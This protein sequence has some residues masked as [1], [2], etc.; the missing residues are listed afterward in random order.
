M[1][2]LLLLP[3]AALGLTLAACSNNTPAATTT[4]TAAPTTT[5]TSSSTSS[6]TSGATGTLPTVENATDLTKAPTVGP[7]T[8]PPPTTLQTKDLVV[9]TGATAKAGDTV[10]VQYV[11]AHYA[12]GTP[13][14]S[15]WSRGQPATF[16]LTGVIPGFAQGIEGMQVG[17]RREIVIPGA[18][19][20]GASPPAGSGIA[21]NETLVFVVDLLGI[22]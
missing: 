3:L 1:R 8:P 17:G 18:L 13:F 6:T 15:S 7:G 21:A 10:K 2:R 19:G 22:S 9:G 5:S 20:Y 11:G 12:S 4:T 14:D 16:P